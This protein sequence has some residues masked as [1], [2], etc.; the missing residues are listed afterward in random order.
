M[1][2]P[3]GTGETE[4]RRRKGHINDH[5]DNQS[6]SEHLR[7]VCTDEVWMKSGQ[8]TDDAESHL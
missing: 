5:L 1:K 2:W 7:N 3:R 6:G 8:M 4:R